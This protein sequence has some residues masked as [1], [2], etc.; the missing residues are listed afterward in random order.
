MPEFKNKEEYQKWK[1]DRI[2]QIE[3][4]PTLKQE[5]PILQAS[6]KEAS[7]EKKCRYCSM[8]IPK[9]AKICPYCR[10]RQYRINRVLDKNEIFGI[11]IIVLVFIPL[12]SILMNSNTKV[13]NYTLSEKMAMIDNN[14]FTPASYQ[15]LLNTIQKDC[16]DY[17]QQRIADMVAA[18]LTDMKDNHNIKDTYYETLLAIKE[19]VAEGACKNFKLEQIIA[20]YAV[21]RIDLK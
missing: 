19:S 6:V 5:E 1:A 17:S 15:V 2:K 18:S 20:M 4:K 21:I 7:I 10:K 8:A 11:L 3:E 12:C 16:P 14:R 13:Y 9:E